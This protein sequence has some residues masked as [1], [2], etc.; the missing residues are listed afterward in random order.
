MIA[1]TRILKN[2]LRIYFIKFFASIIVLNV[3]YRYDCE[4]TECLGAYSG[5]PNTIGSFPEPPE[6]VLNTFILSISLAFFFISET[7]HTQLFEIGSQYD[8]KAHRVQNSI[9]YIH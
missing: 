2:L 8:T 5:L 9:L 4:Q 6:H 1:D 7:E 3:E